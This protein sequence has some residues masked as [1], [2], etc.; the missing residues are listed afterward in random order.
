MGKDPPG[1][2]WYSWSYNIKGE[3]CSCAGNWNLVAC[4][5]C[6]LLSCWLL[7]Q[8]ILRPLRR[9]RHVPPKRRLTFNGLHSVIS[10]RCENL[11]S[12]TFFCM[13]VW[14]EQYTPDLLENTCK[15]IGYCGQAVHVHGLDLPSEVE[16]ILILT[17][18]NWGVTEK[19]PSK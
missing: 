13:R 6:H 3:K 12:A 4:N 5:A 10:H 15:M 11:K 17:G 19:S 9:R 2:L 14:S 1:M 8:L 16:P 18:N 7:A